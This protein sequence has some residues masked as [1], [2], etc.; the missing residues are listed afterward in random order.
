MTLPVSRVGDLYDD[1]DKQL[2]GSEN[3]FANGIGVA[4]V[5]DLTEGHICLPPF[6]SVFAPPAPII[7]GSSTVFA[8]FKPIARVSDKHDV[9][10]CGGP[11]GCCPHTGDFITGSETVFAGG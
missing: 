7:T 4:R 5:D 8:N 2:L 10:L 6:P 11:G 9:H 1:G 3:V